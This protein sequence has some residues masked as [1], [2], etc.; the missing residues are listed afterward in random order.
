MLYFID[1]EIID[2][3]EKGLYIKNKYIN[4]V[5]EV[6]WFFDI[7][8]IFYWVIYFNGY[9]EN[10][11]GNDVYIICIFIDKNGG[12]IWEYFCKLVVEIG[13]MIEDEDN[14]LFK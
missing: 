12:F 7:C 10:F 11:E 1:L 13:L 14:I 2:F 8:Y 5:V 9:Y 3:S 4:N 6:L